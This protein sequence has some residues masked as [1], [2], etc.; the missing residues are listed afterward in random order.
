MKSTN[1]INAKTTFFR[2]LRVDPSAR[3]EFSDMRRAPFLVDPQNAWA[4]FFVGF[5]GIER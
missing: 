3:P 5:E 4:E 2:V 1:T